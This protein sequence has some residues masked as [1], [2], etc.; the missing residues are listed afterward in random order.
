LKLQQLIW[1]LTIGIA[2]G[3]VLYAAGMLWVGA[4]GL[5]AALQD[6]SVGLLLPVIALT[7][8]NYGLRLLRWQLYLRALGLEIPGK[9]NALVFFAGLSMVITPGKIG[10]LLKS[11]L[12]KQACGVAVERTAPVVIAERVTDLAALLVLFAIG[13]SRFRFGVGGLW[14][15]VGMLGVF[16]VVVNSRRTATRLLT[17]LQ[18]RP[19]LVGRMGDKLAVIYQ[20]TH[21][22]FRPRIA[23]TGMVLATLAWFCECTGF[24]LILRELLQP[25]GLGLA[26]FIYSAAT[27]GG[28]P[29]P[30]GLGITDGGMTALLEMTLGTPRN[31]AAAATLMIRLCT[32]WFA[33]GLGGVM[34]LVA[35]WQFRPR[36][37]LVVS[38]PGSGK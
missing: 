29:T 28:I 7:L 17:L 4:D 32:L 22:L 14:A 19:G 24:F 15:I 18:R 38:E 34:L 20:S 36:E 10:E 33:V 27:L 35:Y 5:R 25:A 6:F 16:F 13:L 30:G 23:T 8:A 12:L 31:V 21:L 37:A 2:C 3:V 1:R 11:F 26:S 9:T